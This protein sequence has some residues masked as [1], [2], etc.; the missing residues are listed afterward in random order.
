MNKPT[1]I[2]VM[3]VDDHILVRSGLRVFLL[4]FDDLESIGEASC[5]EEA[6]RICAEVRPD[7]VLMDVVMPGIGGIAATRAICQ[8]YPEVRVITLTNF[9]DNKLVQE[10]LE[11]GAIGYLLK[12]VPAEE[13]VNAIRAAIADQPIPHETETI[14]PQ[15]NLGD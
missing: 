8:H 9:G 12:D 7:V 13:L 14:P 5:G 4:A 15:R 6:L 2:R 1:P 10:T 11:A 3:I